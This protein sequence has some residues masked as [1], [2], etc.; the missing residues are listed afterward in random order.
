VDIG[1]VHFYHFWRHQPKQGAINVPWIKDNRSLQLAQLGYVQDYLDEAKRYLAEDRK[2]FSYANA[3]I[4]PSQLFAEELMRW[5]DAERPW[6]QFANYPW[7]V[8]QSDDKQNDVVYVDYSTSVFQPDLYLRLFALFDELH[9]LTAC[10]GT[11]VARAFH[12][13]ITALGHSRWVRVLKPGEYDHKSRFGVL[14]NL[15]NFRGAAEALPRKLL[16]YLHCGMWPLIHG[17]FAESICYCQKHGIKPLIYYGVKELAQLMGKAGMP[18][19]NKG[20]FCIEERIGDLVG[21]LKGL[22]Q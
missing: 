20:R 2:L 22:G 3:F 17:T 14:V 11:I 18:R 7:C 10:T 15:T 8:T 19:W 9:V 13:D 5:Y 4:A 16:L 12:K 21:Y 1:K 6:F